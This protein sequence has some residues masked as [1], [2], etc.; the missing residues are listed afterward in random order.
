MKK[1]KETQEFKEF[2]VQQELTWNITGDD[3]SRA[4]TEMLNSFLLH[5]LT[6]KLVAQS[7][8]NTYMYLLTYIW[9]KQAHLQN[10]GEMSPNPV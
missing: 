8:A 4:L 3:C 7:G 1:Y 2:S 6:N 10:K 9:Y 5:T